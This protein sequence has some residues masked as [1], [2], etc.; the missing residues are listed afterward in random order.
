MNQD[1][2]DYYLTDDDDTEEMEPSDYRHIPQPTELEFPDRK[3]LPEISLDVVGD[4][5]TDH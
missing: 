3:L 1:E 2:I 4:Q 5:A